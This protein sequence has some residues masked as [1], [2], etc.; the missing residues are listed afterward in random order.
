MH[1]LN[2]DQ[3]SGPNVKRVLAQALSIGDREERHVFV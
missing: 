2:G 1:V 3:H